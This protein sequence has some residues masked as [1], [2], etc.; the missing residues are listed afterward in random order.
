MRRGQCNRGTT[1]CRHSSILLSV[2]HLNQPICHGCFRRFV[3]EE[4]NCYIVPCFSEEVWVQTICGRDESWESLSR[5]V[6]ITPVFYHGFRKGLMTGF[7][8]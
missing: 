2:N 1:E 8:A 6:L 5:V 7:H 4:S 3:F